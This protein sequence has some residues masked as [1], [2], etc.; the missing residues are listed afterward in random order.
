MKTYQE[1]EEALLQFLIKA[2]AR[3]AFKTAAVKQSVKAVSKVATPK[4]LKLPSE[5]TGFQTARG[6][7]YI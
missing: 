3:Q 6:S 7:K 5:V 4:K 1:L 2:A